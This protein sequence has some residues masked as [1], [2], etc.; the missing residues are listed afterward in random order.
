VSVPHVLYHMVGDLHGMII[1]FVDLTSTY[2]YKEAVKKNQP[3]L[4]QAYA[5]ALFHAR[6]Y[7][8]HLRTFF[9]SGDLGKYRDIPR[10]MSLFSIAT[11]SD[12]T[13]GN[14]TPIKRD[15]PKRPQQVITPDKRPASRPA[16]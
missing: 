9:A 14:S 15:Q 11:N 8:L 16:P 5:D 12:G 6:T 10:L 13:Q 4:A 2:S 7:V 1:P 3:I